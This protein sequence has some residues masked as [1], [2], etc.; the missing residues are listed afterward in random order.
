VLHP[1]RGLTDLALPGGPYTELIIIDEVDRLNMP[2]LEALRDYHHCT[3]VG[4]ILIGMPG[5]ERRLARYHQLRTP[6]SH[7]TVNQR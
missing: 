5:I 1:D 3:G 7:R 4:L 2:S 6:C